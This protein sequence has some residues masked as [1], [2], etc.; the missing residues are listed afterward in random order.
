MLYLFMLSA[1]ADESIPQ[2]VFL[3]ENI[4]LFVDLG[5]DSGWVPNS[6]ALGVRLELVANGGV[7][8]EQY[9]FSELSWSMI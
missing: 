2:E 5:L 8:V 6:G 3:Q 4:P 9:G 7:G 1:M